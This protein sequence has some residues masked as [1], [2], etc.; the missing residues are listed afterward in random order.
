MEALNN[1]IP[2]KEELIRWR[3]GQFPEGSRKEEL[4]KLFAEDPF[5]ADAL[6]GMEFDENLSGMPAHPNKMKG[7]GS[8]KS[9]F[10]GWGIG[11]F[12]GLILGGGGYL[13]LQPDHH[14]TI[15][16]SEPHAPQNNTVGTLDSE[17][18][19]PLNTEKPKEEKKKTNP[20][21]EENANPPQSEIESTP[22]IPNKENWQIQKQ[23][24]TPEIRSEIPTIEL[25]DQK[26]YPYYERVSKS[27]DFTI[28]PNHVEAAYS[29]MN[30]QK[31]DLDQLKKLGYLKYLEQA[32]TEMNDENWSV[33][34]MAFSTILSQYSDDINA[35]FYLGQSL[36]HLGE[37]EKA[38]KYFQASLQHSISV[39]RKESAEFYRLC[40]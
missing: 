31:Q 21:M 39:F 20:L 4:Q 10:L 16:T 1:P 27:E 8:F 12:I 30:A 40:E 9:H 38:K 3:S 6:A 13:I 36:Y 18:T 32:L 33:A 37:K 11:I 22:F 29:D 23:L 25:A 17:K 14:Q 24:P 28:D 26:V 19:M 35:Q 5:L 2:S 34:K 7:T 15:S